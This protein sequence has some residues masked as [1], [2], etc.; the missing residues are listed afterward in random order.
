[1]VTDPD[2]V[3]G[4]VDEWHERRLDVP[5]VLRRG[6]VPRPRSAAARGDP[7]AT[8]S[9]GDTVVTVVLP[10][11]V[12]RHWWEN[13]LH[14]QTALFFKRVLLF[15][16]GVVVTSVPV[17]PRRSRG[18]APSDAAAVL[19]GPAAHRRRLSTAWP[20]PSSRSRPPACSSA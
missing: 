7:R 8:P 2:E 13:L 18:R 3:E 16:P 15:E 14:N 4:V 1:M 9:R 6:A 20:R 10:E 17:P 5:L 19:G 11:L 12:P